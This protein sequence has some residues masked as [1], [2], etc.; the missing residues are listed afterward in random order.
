M[1]C[2]DCGGPLEMMSGMLIC[3]DCEGLNKTLDDD[4]WY[5][6]DLDEDNS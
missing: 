5:Q 1:K 2:P 3:P 6:G 4:T